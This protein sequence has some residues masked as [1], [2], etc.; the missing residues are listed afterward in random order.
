M[1]HHLFA[2]Q[3]VYIYAP[4]INLLFKRQRSLFWSKRP[5]FTCMSIPIR[6]I[7]PHSGKH[8]HTQPHP[9]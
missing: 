6:V 2:G 7:S 4:H 8:A 9:H 5:P 1:K 3:N